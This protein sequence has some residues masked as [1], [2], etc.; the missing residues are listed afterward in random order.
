MYENASKIK[1]I[2]LRMDRLPGWSFPWRVL[3]VIGMA[4]FFAFFDIIVIGLGLPEII[5]EFHISQSITTWSIT[6]GLIGYIFGSFIDARISDLLGRKLSLCLSVAFYT[7]GCFLSATSTNIYWLIGWR[8]ITG[9]GLGAEIAAAVTYLS[10]LSPPKT[11][12]KYVA[13]AVGAGFFG[14]ALSPFVGLAILPFITWGWR[15]LFVIGGVGGTIFFI[16]RLFLP[17]SPRWLVL[18]DKHELAEKIVAKMEETSKKRYKHEL[19]PI[20]ESDF[21]QTVLPKRS[22]SDLFRTGYFKRLLLFCFIW[23]F[24]YTGNYAW[25]TLNNVLFQKMGYS[26]TSSILYIC[27]FSLGF[28]LGSLIAIKFSDRFERKWFCFTVSIIWSFCLLIVGWF[29]SPA[30]IMIFGFLASTTISIIIPLMYGYTAENFPTSYRTT[31]VSISDGFGH[32]GAAFCGQIVFGIYHLFSTTKIGFQAAYTA[33]A[34]T[35]LITAIL[36][37]FGNKMTKKSLMSTSLDKNILES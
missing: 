8:F 32:I 1:A 25:L 23:I 5:K 17:R 20:D 15:L 22:L 35:G 13:L 26:Q 21:Q 11:R 28:I 14:F 7:L 27:I 4:Y 34:I 10:E 19:S 37:A 2:N 9:L 18:H 6:S 30:I 33:M 36:L 16:F 29:V 24:Y 3:I 31:A 12:G